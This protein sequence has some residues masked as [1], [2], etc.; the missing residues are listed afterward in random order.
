MHDRDA[1]PNSPKSR[2]DK[3]PAEGTSDLAAPERE[4]RGAA[5][6]AKRGRGCWKPRSG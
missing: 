4:P 6:S 3:R 5:A 2:L 1:M